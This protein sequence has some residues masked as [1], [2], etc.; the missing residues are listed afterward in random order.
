MLVV[1]IWFGFNIVLSHESS[2]KYDALTVN[3]A[4]KWTYFFKAYL[5]YVLHFYVNQKLNYRR[6][7][8]LTYHYHLLSSDLSP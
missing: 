6:Y 7:F 8:R 1:I 3:E 5:V 4:N 2:I